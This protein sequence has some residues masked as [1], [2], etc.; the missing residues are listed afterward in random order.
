MSDKELLE[1]IEK[2]DD[3][4][5]NKL[6]N[7]YWRL[8][9]QWTCNRIYDHDAVKDL[10]QNYWADIWSKPTIIKTDKNGSAK[11]ILLGFISYRILDFY[12]KKKLLVFNNQENFDMK[13]SET[14]AY[15]HVF[16]EV[17]IK[18]AH[19]LINKLLNKMP[20]LSRDIYILHEKENYSVKEISQKLSITEETVR[21]KLAFTRKTLKNQFLK[22][23][24]EG[25]PVVVFIIYGNL[26]RH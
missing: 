14:L 26:F 9:Y 1:L 23:Y 8:I 3:L 10:L 21:R 18:D 2:N 24:S 5:F 19:K 4:A 12:K 17:E 7:K 15:T 25:V 20:D 11:A 13:N 22:Y 16:E 6:Y